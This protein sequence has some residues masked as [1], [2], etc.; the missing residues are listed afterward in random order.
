MPIM[1]LIILPIA[2]NYEVK[3]INITVIDN[4]HSSFS[5]RQL[6]TKITSSG[7][8]KLTDYNYSF[9][10]AL[11]LIE[12]DQADLILEIPRGFERNLVRENANRN[13]LLQ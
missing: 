8:F 2:A 10:D 1:Q 3:N 11:K 4:D 7:Y 5:K 13:Y 12:S 6:I 9:K